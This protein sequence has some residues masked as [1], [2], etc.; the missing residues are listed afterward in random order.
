MEN[1]FPIKPFTLPARGSV[2]LPGSKSITN[3]ALVLAALSDRS[4]RLEKVL[5]SEDT[6]IMITALKT[7]GFSIEVDAAARTIM[8]QGCG[9]I[10]P[11]D[12]ASI[13]VGNAGTAARF[14]TALLAL[15]PKGTYTLDGS[16]A[17]R[18]RPMQGLLDA[19]TAMGTAFSFHGEPGHFPFTMHTH[20]LRG[21]TVSLDAKTSSQLL[22]ALLM[23]APYSCPVAEE[24]L[25]INLSGDTISHPFIEMTL[26]MMEQFGQTS[27]VESH[28]YKVHRV[29]KGKHSSDLS[30]Y[31]IEADVT[32]ASYFLALPIVTGGEVVLENC[33]L[34]GLQGDARFAAFLEE[35][36]LLSIEAVGDGGVRSRRGQ[37]RQ[38]I[39][40]D[41]NA[42]SDTFLTLAAIAPLLEGPTR[43]TGIAHT[44]KQ[45]TDRV[46]AMANELRRL[47]QEVHETE[48]AL[49]IYPLPLQ[50]ATIHTYEDH[51]VAMSF[52]LLGCYDLYQNGSSWLKIENPAC[53][54]KTFPD[55]F[56]VLEGLY[57]GS[58]SMSL[59]SDFVTVALD[60]ASASGKS[61]TAKAL[62]EQF[63]FLHVDTGSHYRALTNVFLKRG[64]TADQ[65][66]AIEDCLKSI[67]VETQVVERSAWMAIDGAL[68]ED[69]ELRSPLVNESV[70]H[71]SAL[72]VVRDFLLNFQRSQVDVARKY[73][74]KG[75]VMEG[76]DI[77]S[78]VL[79]DANFRFFLEA[80]PEVRAQRRAQQGQKDVIAHRDHL[81]TA[82]KVAP[83]T[84]P[85]GAIRI[86]TSEHS[87]EEVVAMVCKTIGSNEAS[88]G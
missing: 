46:A 44:R 70:S 81:D 43:I 34:D 62:A 30:I 47:G 74:F 32:A 45:E 69:A 72:P 78:V 36:G 68:P 23:A 42:I 67:S 15:H 1:P 82:R 56:D 13:Q 57:Q 26:K 9:G 80:A 3:R 10:L 35:A 28:R 6:H 61:S 73:L 87:L 71:F 83:L 76:R 58:H 14:L 4:V 29:K 54:A 25:T 51:R 16:A 85:E 39:D 65:S 7:L 41:F 88:Q 11:N 66:E 77:G 12:S 22:S 33:V 38:G 55:F 49:E 5:L 52:G 86:D 19:L 50:P 17:M 27:G 40:R 31:P 60:G 48:D 59:R 37:S 84:C 18:R 64:L 8:V 63:N 53:C 20:G 21:D 75:L 2:R 79:T 24:V